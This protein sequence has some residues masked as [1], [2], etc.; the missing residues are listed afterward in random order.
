MSRN[1][2]KEIKELT[3]SHVHI[4]N[5][6]KVNEKIN[7]IVEDGFNNLQIVSDFDLTITKQH[8]NGKRH[9]SSFCKY[10]I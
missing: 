10:R 2:V 7:G 1:F 5:A 4:K 8:E 9:I 6:E 3:K